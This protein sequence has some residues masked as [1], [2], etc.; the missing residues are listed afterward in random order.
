M[1][2]MALGYQAVPVPGI[3]EFISVRVINTYGL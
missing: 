3:S 2:H 1:I